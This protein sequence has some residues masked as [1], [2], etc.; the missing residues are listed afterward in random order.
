MVVKKAIKVPYGS[1]KATMG[2]QYNV[3]INAKTYVVDYYRTECI[4]LQL[5]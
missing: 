1:D 3:M 4:V 5:K 2:T